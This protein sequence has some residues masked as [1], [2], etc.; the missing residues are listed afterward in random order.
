MVFINF[1]YK[2]RSDIAEWCPLSCCHTL[3]LLLK[4]NGIQKPG[5]TKITFLNDTVK[6]NKLKQ[7]FCPK[8]PSLKSQLSIPL[9]HVTF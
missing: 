7:L 6:V 9:I 2:P 1:L 4:I 8:G 5:L 3:Q